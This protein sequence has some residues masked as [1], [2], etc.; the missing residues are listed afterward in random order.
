LLEARARFCPLGR[1]ARPS[2]S[3]RPPPYFDGL[4]AAI[5]RVNGLVLVTA[6]VKDF[7]AFK[8][9]SVENWKG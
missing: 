5:A 6:N 8:E 3:G 1:E 4:I 2:K 7:R 9:L